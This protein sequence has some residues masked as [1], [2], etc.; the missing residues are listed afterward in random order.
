MNT[1]I[2]IQGASGALYR[3]QLAEN[4]RPRTAVSGTYIYVKA[5]Q[6]LEVVYAGET[7]NLSEGSIELWSQASKDYG[8][9]HLYTRLNVA[10]AAREAELADLLATGEPPMNKALQGTH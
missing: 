3:Y 7:I 10:G 8:A 4:A 6:H 1:W 5:G 9:T 2:D